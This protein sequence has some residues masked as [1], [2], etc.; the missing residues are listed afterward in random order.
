M[1]FRSS[2]ATHWDSSQATFLRPIMEAFKN[3]AIN[4]ITCLCSAQSAKTETMIAL[5]L[6]AIAEDPGPILWVTTNQNEARKI[7][8]S[9]IMPMIDR[10]AP[11]LDKLPNG[12]YD[13][14]TTTIFFPGAPLVIAG[15][16]SSANLQSTPY[17]YIF[18]DEV[19]SWKAGALEMVSK[20]TRSFPH[21]YK[22]VVVTTPAM[23]NDTAHR[24]FLSGSQSHYHV[25]CPDC[26]SDFP[27]FWGDRNTSGGLKWEES[28]RTMPEGRIDF[29]KILDTIHYKCWGCGKTWEDTPRDRKAL[30][31][32]GRWIEYNDGHAPNSLSFSWNAL[33]PWWPKWK[34]Q[35]REFLDARETS[36]MGSWKGMIDHY[37]ETRGLVWSKDYEFA[38]DF[39][40]LDDRIEDYDVTDHEAAAAAMKHM[41]PAK[42]GGA[43]N[44]IRVGTFDEVRRFLTLDVQGKGGRHYWGVVRAWAKDGRSRYLDHGKFFTVEEWEKFADRWSVTP[45]NRII[46][47][48]HWA[49]EIYQLIIKSGYRY[50]AFKGEKRD[51]FVAKGINGAE[52]RMVSVSHVDP[53]QGTS[54]QGQLGTIPLILFSK[55]STCDRL[56]A[57]LHGIMPGW[58]IPAHVDE[59]YRK[60]VTAYYR[61]VSVDNNGSEKHE[62]R[63]KRDDHLADCERMQIAAAA[64]TGII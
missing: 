64:M 13:R 24:A 31:N 33:L 41:A 19:R 44:I 58:T 22:K 4:E 23:A 11:I 10:C 56:D 15:A 21:S 39:G 63:S 36:K 60:Q 48:G 8:K 57:Y 27:L 62:W 46:D 52:K 17:R 38:D 40:T 5:L 54:Q 37:N 26:G 29:A 34:D 28:E 49:T 59:T 12:R 25:V 42:P 6:W 3:P 2:A 7:A 50:K 51:F 9:R 35:V 18:L 45:D 1:V 47:A 55:P 14:S 61:H 53:A 43:P 30:S 20:R 16:D 32:S